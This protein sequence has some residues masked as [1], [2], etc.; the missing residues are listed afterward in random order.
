MNKSMV[1]GI[2]VGVALAAG[3]G[4]I[5]AYNL[6]DGQDYAKVLDVQAVTKDI[7]TP[8]QVCQDVTTTV[9]KPVQDENRVAGSVIGA[10]VGGVLGHQIGDGNG[11]KI[12]TVAGAA[13]GGY[14]GNQVQKNMQDGDLTTR[15]DRKCHTAYDRSQKLL[16]YDVTYELDGKQGKVRMA[17]RPDDT[18]PVQNGQLQF[19]A[20]NS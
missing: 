14:A 18:I 8:R 10:V 9:R 16:G 15:T 7:S 5:A 12:A 3:G 1:A 13:A 6:N 20:P 2:A 11:R 4:A 17:H 19:E